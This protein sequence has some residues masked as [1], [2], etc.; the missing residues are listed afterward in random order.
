M[1]T[2]NNCYIAGLFDGEGSCSGNCISIT[3]TNLPILKTVSRYLHNINIEN[4][5]MI[6]KYKAKKYYKT[7]YDIRIYGRKNI[8]NFY[9]YI[10]FQIREKRIAMLKIIVNTKSVIN[11]EEFKQIKKDV[12]LG[13]S[14]REASKKYNHPFTTIYNYLHKISRPNN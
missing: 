8:D 7:A 6:R 12:L 4:T 13:M 5:I 10:P 14:Y 9:T 11:K 3:N 2:N 1:K